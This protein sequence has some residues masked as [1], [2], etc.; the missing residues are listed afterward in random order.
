MQKKIREI[1]MFFMSARNRVLALPG[2]E[3]SGFRLKPIVTLFSR[4]GMNF[5]RCGVAEIG[6]R[7]AKIR[8]SRQLGASGD[9][10]RAP[11]VRNIRPRPFN[12]YEQAIAKADQEKDVN[13]QPGQPCDEARDVKFAKLRDC[14]GPSDGGKAAFIPIVKSRARR[15]VRPRGGFSRH[16]Q[17]TL[18][19]FWGG[20]AFLH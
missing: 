17:L 20:P 8:P 9:Q 4:N 10:A 19:D 2:F 18:N 11:L 15:G 5:F 7:R 1:R 3:S 14:R 12:E 16:F 13:E 6:S